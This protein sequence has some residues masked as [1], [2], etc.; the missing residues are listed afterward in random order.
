MLRLMT[1]RTTSKTVTF[2]RPFVLSATGPQPAGVYEVDTDEEAIDR[3]SFLAYHRIATFMKVHRAE[4]TEVFRI[5]PVELESA[6][7][8]DAGMTVVPT[9]STGDSD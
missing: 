4:T 3:L 8:R 5:N 2:T 6:L 1:A 7:L 9:G